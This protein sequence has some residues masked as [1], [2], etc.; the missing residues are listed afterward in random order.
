M[1]KQFDFMRVYR[2]TI[3]T[4]HSGPKTFKSKVKLKRHIAAYKAALARKKNPKQKTMKGSGKLSL[5]LN[6]YRCKWLKKNG[7]QCGKLELTSNRKKHDNQHK[8]AEKA[9]GKN[10]D[11]ER[12]YAEKLRGENHNSVVFHTGKEIGVPDIVMYKN[13]K[14]SF[15]EVKPTGKGNESLLKVSQAK[16]IKKNCL[17]KK[18]DVYLVR[19]KS[20]TNKF[21]FTKW[22]LNKNNIGMY[23][24]S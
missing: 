17:G 5:E 18:I 12:Q 21:T 8:G 7:K 11:S 4:P 19:Y 24:P 16:W 3:R 2:C 10:I 6:V 22:K 9:S 1:I 20:R 14:L 23:T 13:E 15:Y